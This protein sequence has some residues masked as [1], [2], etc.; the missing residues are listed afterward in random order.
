MEEGWKYWNWLSH[1]RK[2]GTGARMV[3]SEI[4][5]N[6]NISKELKKISKQKRLEKSIQ[7]NQKKIQ[8]RK[9]LNNPTKEKHFKKFKYGRRVPEICECPNKILYLED[10]F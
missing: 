10:T 1:H 2:V 9:E 3:Q 8:E 4:L 5:G 6:S 7:K